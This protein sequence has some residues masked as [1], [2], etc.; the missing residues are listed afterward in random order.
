M[1]VNDF[2]LFSAKVG[3]GSGVIYQPMNKHD[4]TYILTANHNL[5][6]ERNNER[7]EKVKHQLEYIDILIPNNYETKPLSVELIKN[8]YYFPHNDADIAI[9]KINFL[10]G[11]EKIYINSSFTELTNTDLCGYPYYLKDKDNLG[12]K[13]NSSKIDSFKSEN[14]TF[15]RAQ[16]NDNNSEQSHITGFSGGG[17][18]KI[19]NDY[20][21]LIGIQSEVT[22]HFSKGEIEFV[23]IKYFEDIINYTENE[24]QLSPLLPP[25]MS[26]FKY[27]KDEIIKL[28]GASQPSMINKIKSAFN[29]QMKFIGL[30][31]YLI[32][33]SNIGTKLLANKTSNPFSKKLWV[34]WLEYLTIL[35]FVENREINIDNI[36][37]IFNNKRL[38]HSDTGLNWIEIIPDLLKDN[39]Q[40]LENNGTLIVST[41]NIPLRKNSRRYKFDVIQDIFFASGGRNIGAIHVDQAKNIKKLKEIIHINAFENDCILESEGIF[42]NISELE[43]GEIILQLKTIINDFFKS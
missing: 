20:I 38:I 17:I 33:N 37:A 28:E 11:Y 8:E 41:H 25:Y 5:F 2:K 21:S 15:C 32:Y 24:G 19:E 30:N 1:G 3:K 10:E 12:E 27:L 40:G 14:N 6:E 13:Y 16:L 7:G 43:I 4:Y 29:E 23:P 9:L 34:A 22:S 42:N 35:S 36:E 31:P 26:A 18:M 39:L